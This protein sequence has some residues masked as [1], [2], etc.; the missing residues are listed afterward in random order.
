MI[1]IRAK[2]VNTVQGTMGNLEG[3]WPLDKKR[4]WI[5]RGDEV[6]DK[7][8]MENYGFSLGE[9]SPAV[10]RIHACLVLSPA[11]FPQQIPFPSFLLKLGRQWTVLQPAL[12]FQIW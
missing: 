1:S 8:D 10:S 3:Q 12:L 9:L 6:L 11:F 4:V 2:S 5:G 7:E